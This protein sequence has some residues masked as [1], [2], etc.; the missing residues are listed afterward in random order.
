MAVGHSRTMIFDRIGPLAQSMLYDMGWELDP[1]ARIEQTCA[2]SQADP[3]RTVTNASANVHK[4]PDR[5]FVSWEIPEASEVTRV[6][7]LSPRQPLW[8][9]WFYTSDT[10]FTYI[11]LEGRAG[12]SAWQLQ[13]GKGYHSSFIPTDP[14][15]IVEVNAH[16]PGPGK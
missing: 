12:T 5:I 1:G 3:V 4:N 11:N 2:A 10:Q 14:N 16:Y 8:S 15:D 7:G 9:V 13:S 6:R